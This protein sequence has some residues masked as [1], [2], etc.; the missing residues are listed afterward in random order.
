MGRIYICI[1]VIKTRTSAQMRDDKLISYDDKYRVYMFHGQ[2]SQPQ[3]I[4]V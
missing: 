3:Q 2:R 4:E 1:C